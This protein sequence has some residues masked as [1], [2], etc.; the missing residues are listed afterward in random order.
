MLEGLTPPDSVRPCSVRTLLNTLDESDQ[1]ILVNA[2]AADITVW[3]HVA[4][5]NA[6]R[7]RDIILLEQ[8]IR[9]HRARRCSCERVD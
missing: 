9:K 1:A 4:L 2:L 6:L 3:G 5:Q 8:A 7:E